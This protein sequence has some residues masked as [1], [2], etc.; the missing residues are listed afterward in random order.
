MNKTMLILVL[1][2]ISGIA[3]ADQCSY[4]SNRQA[5]KAVRALIGAQYIHTFCEP[6]GDTKAQ[7]VLAD[8]VSLRKTGIEKTWEVLI[9]QQG[10]DLA[11]IYVDG[12]N[13]AKVVS[14]PTEGVSPTLK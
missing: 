13:L 9:N 8:S 12:L 6:C 3:F 7:I 5:K 14:C 2:L 10:I 4:I 11:Y 1:S